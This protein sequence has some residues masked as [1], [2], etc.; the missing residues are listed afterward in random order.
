ML[1][2]CLSQSQAQLVAYK[3][4]LTQI[5]LNYVKYLTTQ[6]HEHSENFSR[7]YTES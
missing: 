7:E 6:S 1:A 2:R 3:T 5:S 4:V